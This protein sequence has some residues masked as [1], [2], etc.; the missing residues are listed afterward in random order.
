MFAW[1]F[2]LLGVARYLP[3]GVDDDP[4]RVL[5]LPFTASSQSRNAQVVESI[6]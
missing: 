6:D 1:D 5:G 2:G 3:G 4:P